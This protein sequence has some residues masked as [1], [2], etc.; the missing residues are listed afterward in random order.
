MTTRNRTRVARHLNRMA[1]QM[2][3][4]EPDDADLLA[5]FVDDR[6]GAAFE[7]IVRRHGPKV[8]GICRRVL[9]H[10][11]DAE[12]AFQ[13]AFLILARKAG[14]VGRRES[15]GCWLYRVAYRAALR[16]KIR[17][18][19]RTR[20]ESPAD[21][22]PAVE[23]TPDLIWAD[24]R[25]ILD[26]EVDRLPAKY[27]AAFVLC[28]LDGKTNQQAARELGCPHGTVLSRLAWARERLRARL[29]RRG[30]A[31]SA[32]VVI[33]DLAN[34]TA[35][36]VVP[37]VLTETTLKSVRLVAAGQAVAAVVPWPVAALTI[38]A[39]RTM[40]GTK[41]LMT[42]CLLAVAAVGVGFGERRPQAVP[43]QPPARPDQPDKAP[44]KAEAA[45]PEKMYAIEFRDKPW[46]AVLEWYA[47]ITGLPFIASTKPAGT[48]TFIPPSS[49][50]S[51]TLAEITDILNEGLLPGKFIL[52]QRHASFTVLPADEKHDRSLLPRVRPEDLD[53]RGR[54]ELVTVILPLTNLNTWNVSPDVKKLLGMFGEMVALDKA[55]QIV[56][57]DTVSNVRLIRELIRE[58]EDREA[59]KQAGPKAK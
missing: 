21:D 40:L 39:T 8:L 1:S 2:R 13:A 59:A 3:P 45:K 29:T 24:V 12:D 33:S 32:G 48:F 19:Q 49:K 5:R 41:V 31:L 10:A 50:K 42:T 37:A 6:D 25:P 17:T 14:S 51:Y 16:A 36:A 57:S 35:T 27:R 43:Q 34:G 54:T 15:V 53:K 58:L 52:V 23:C 7:M 22:V 9:R 20:R 26:E 46:S 30:L 28:Y 11:H 4:G 38:G 18:D 44:A 55:N 56:V 47:E